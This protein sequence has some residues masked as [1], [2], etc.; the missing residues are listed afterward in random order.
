MY[1]FLLKLLFF[2]RLKI[3]YAIVLRIFFPKTTTV[4]NNCKIL[5]EINKAINVYIKI[6]RYLC[7][8]MKWLWQSNS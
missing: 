8:L 7:L 5:K 1:L 2:N 6:K 3:V 4:I